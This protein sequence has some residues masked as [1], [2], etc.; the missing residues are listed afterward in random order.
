MELVAESMRANRHIRASWALLIR[1]K[2]EC[3]FVE[4][5]CTLH[6]VCVRGLD[7]GAL[8]EWVTGFSM[9]G[10]IVVQAEMIKLVAIVGSKKRFPFLCVVVARRGS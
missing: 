6:T 10:W 7:A 4:W 3:L 9:T 2:F 5:L 1:R 8:S